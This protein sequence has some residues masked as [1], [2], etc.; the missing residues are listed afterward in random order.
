MKKT[1]L[2]LTSA[3]LSLGVI[4]GIGFSAFYF[5]T[6]G[7]VS[8][9]DEFV[10]HV[11]NLPDNYSL[12]STQDYYDVYFFPQPYQAS[13]VTAGEA[14]A[15][16]RPADSGTWYYPTGIEGHEYHTDNSETNS[17]T[18]T[19]NIIYDHNYNFTLTFGNGC[20]GSGGDYDGYWTSGDYRPK[21]RT[22]YRNLTSEV[23]SEVGSPHCSMRDYY[24]YQLSF[25]GWT[26]SQEAA[27]NYGYGRQTGFSILDIQTSLSTYDSMLPDGTVV[28]AN[29]MDDYRNQ[30][31]ID[32]SYIGD[33]RVYLYPIYTTGKDYGYWISGGT[34]EWVSVDWVAH[35]YLEHDDAPAH[36]RRVSPLIDSVGAI[37][38]GTTTWAER[39]FSNADSECFVIRNFRGGS[40]AKTHVA[41]VYYAD[42][43]A[44]NQWDGTWYD[45]SLNLPDGQYNIYV[46]LQ[47]DFHGNYNSPIV[48]PEEVQQKIAAN[49]FIRELNETWT[50]LAGDTRIHV[51]VERLYDFKLVGGITGTLDYDSE[52]TY[53]AN[54]YESSGNQLFYRIDDVYFPGTENYHTIDVGNGERYND[55]VFSIAS[56]SDWRNLDYTVNVKEGDPYLTT[57][58]T[59]GVDYDILSGNSAKAVGMKGR[60][61][62][63]DLTI[64]VTFE[65]TQGNSNIASVEVSAQPSQNDFSVLIYQNEGD[66]VE[67]GGFFDASLSASPI[68]RRDFHVGDGNVEELRGST[69]FGGTTLAQIL[70]NNGGYLYDYVTGR[71]FALADFENPEKPFEVTKSYV[72]YLQPEVAN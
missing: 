64:T 20:I 27:R 62:M 54:R 67:T 39:L 1:F 11:D 21:I 36:T 35:R 25:C 40:D 29:E 15:S 46:F 31:G 19:W 28:P 57:D 33:N 17:V 23:L 58:L 59:D 66:I 26:Y 9:E 41:P 61:G 56:S 32:G 4:V 2:S 50:S 24:D 43:N 30:I 22:V 37:S 51:L 34:D 42:S 68:A 38:G 45:T 60:G 70:E 6:G 18:F 72:F 65:Q 63:Y 5:T 49:R 53:Y 16:M 47:S 52:K 71:R 12:D 48:Y 10:P 8:A 69:D 13:T 3:L 14:V 55:Y 44:T 7:R